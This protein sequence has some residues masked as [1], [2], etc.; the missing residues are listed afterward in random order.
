M[1]FSDN[2]T[3]VIKV[4]QMA[5]TLISPSAG[6]ESGFLPH[7]LPSFFRG[8]ARA[9]PLRGASSLEAVKVKAQLCSLMLLASA[10][11]A[12]FFLAYL[13]AYSRSLSS[14]QSATS[15]KPPRRAVLAGV[16]PSRSVTRNSEWPQPPA[17]SSHSRHA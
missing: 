11:A 7:F 16:C 13:G 3:P 5:Q 1:Y 4:R 15:V 12:L 10:C 14:S 17:L 6:L 9:V 8:F 2:A